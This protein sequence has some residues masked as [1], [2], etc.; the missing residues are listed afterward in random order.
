M[1]GDVTI[2]GTGFPAGGTLYPNTTDYSV[3]EDSTPLDPSDTSGGVGTFSFGITDNG[4]SAPTFRGRTAVLADGAQGT[5]T[6]TVS[7]LSSDGNTIT[8]SAD[9]RLIALNVTRT[10][11]PYSGTLS[12]CLN[13]YLGLVN[14]TTGIVVD[15]TLNPPTTVNLLKAPSGRR[16]QAG[17][18][19]I[20]NG[21]GVL[22][23]DAGADTYFLATASIGSGLGGL[24][25]GIFTVGTDLSP[26]T[27]Y[28]FSA[29]VDG[30]ATT[31]GVFVNGAG[32]ASG[33]A[34]VTPGTIGSFVRASTT[35]TTGT[36]GT[37]NVSVLNG[38]ALV[39]GNV[40]AF[41]DAQLEKGS[42]A[43]PYFDGYSTTTVP[44]ASCY[45][46]GTPDASTSVFGPT[47]IAIAGWN[48]NVWDKI[49]QFAASYQFEVSLVS[50]NIVARAPR[51]RIAQNY[52]D[53]QASWG[54]S[55][56]NI[57]R[58]VEVYYYQTAQQA[59]VLAYP[60]GGWNASIQP[61]QVNAGE[62]LTTTLPLAP[63][64]GTPGLI[65]SLTSVTQPTCVDSV[66]RF[67]TLSSVYCV[68]GNDGLPIPAAQWLTAGGSLSVA[69]APDTR[70]LIV[71]IT[72]SNDTQ[73]APFRIGMSSG[74]SNFYSSLRIVGSG[75][76]GNKVMARFDTG[77]TID[78]APTEVGAT[79]DSEFVI[80]Y[81]DAVRVGR[82]AVARCT[83]P[84]HTINV[85]TTG[86]NKIGDPG[87]YAYPTMGQFNVDADF[88]GK[89]MAQFNTQFSGWTMKQFNDYEFAKV[90]GNFENQAFGNVAGAR[91]LWRN[92]YFR[93]R[94]ATIGAG[95]VSYT[96]ERDTTM[97]DFNT[98]DA[99][100]T[101]AQFNAIHAGETMGDF[102]AA[103]LRVS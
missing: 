48:G 6:G 82:A 9:S 79:I 4:V 35:F 91:V 103:P 70:S 19:Y 49:R 83:G 97:A 96:A 77:N 51:Q 26:N 17:S 21:T 60:L 102:N 24:T 1:S 100:L 11:Q 94:N 88:A 34:F 18:G 7:G 93:I 69:I 76:F 67:Y 55:N 47:P 32:V 12:G 63:S 59:N 80:G 30:N 54:I 36:S 38:G 64:Q 75:V 90:S 50:N 73:Y 87:S 41:R 37:V 62:T 95:S 72:G 27:T 28:T 101:M 29:S 45:W 3:I 31:A 33:G 99:G 53:A 58:A 78:Q 42:A 61:L 98:A 23:Y 8:V 14:L 15:S 92:G 46:T 57:A 5:T 20:I 16:N 2:S 71:T 86:I 13:Y 10:A 39:S 65:A 40:I 89:T 68:A 81:L 43:T 74:T 85:Q 84:T 22:G 44:Y 56:S 66:D 25:L 52:R